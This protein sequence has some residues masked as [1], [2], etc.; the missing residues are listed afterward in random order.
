MLLSRRSAP[1]KRATCNFICTWHRSP[2]TTS[3]VSGVSNTGVGYGWFVLHGWEDAAI[4]TASSI[5]HVADGVE[6]HGAIHTLRDD[7]QLVQQSE[8][9]LHLRRVR[10]SHCGRRGCASSRGSLR[11]G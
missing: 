1:A 8:R 4:T 6:A 2:A 9:L 5:D 11:L 10:A 3:Q 7:V